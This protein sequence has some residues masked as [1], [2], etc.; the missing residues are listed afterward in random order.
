MEEF[1]RLTARGT[2]RVQPLITHEYPLEQASEAY[3]MI[4]SPG[5]PSLAVLLQY[6]AATAPD[7]VAHFE[8]KR[9]VDL[10]I[11]GDRK[12]SGFGVAVVGAG[13][14]AKWEHLPILQKID[15]IEL[16]AIHSANGARG[17]GY[18]Q[19]FGAAYCT[20]EYDEILA[21]ASVDA[22]LIATRN[23]Q[24]APQSLAALRA[25][26]HVFVEKPMA[27]TIPECQELYRAVQETGRHLTVGFNRRFA[28][29][30]AA[31]KGALK[32]RVSPAVVSCRINSPGISGNY[33]MADPSIGGAI[34]GEACH[35]VDLMYWLL[36]S[37]PVEISA[38][39]LPTG[40]QDPVGENS[41]AASFRFADGS[42]GNITYCTVGSATSGG[43]LV[44]VF[45]QGI[46]A[47]TEDFKRL[48]IKGKSRSQSTKIWP[49]KGYAEQLKSFFDRVRSGKAPEIDVVDGA[50]AT[51]GCVGMLE[52][53]RT[54]Q[55]FRMDTLVMLTPSAVSMQTAQ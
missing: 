26:K 20:T 40:K 3:K 45:A 30:Y 7:P 16:R 34:L 33:W 48:V 44:E 2:I 49:D 38:Y 43:E 22:V 37:E 4:M 5:S 28:P 10:A 27:L 12:T 24:H 18:A 13:N 6:P 46:G 54:S 53:A 25:G 35:F 29:Y 50:R 9:R 42:V 17:K 55:P 47:S 21:D 14:L 36:G 52:S 19:R 39:C 11:P 15:G 1:L 32:G 31:V 8:P 41:M 23:P 51:I